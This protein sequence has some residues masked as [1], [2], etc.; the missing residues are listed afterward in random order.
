MWLNSI[1]EPKIQLLR[2]CTSV[3]KFCFF[4]FFFCSDFEGCT[5]QCETLLVGFKLNAQ[6]LGIIQVVDVYISLRN[7]MTRVVVY[8]K[9]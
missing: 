5:C 8:K 6:G 2:N 9:H 1:E 7:P 3:P 4:K